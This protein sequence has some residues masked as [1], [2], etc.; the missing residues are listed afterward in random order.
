[1]H[2]DGLV[3]SLADDNSMIG[4]AAANVLKRLQLSA[5]EQDGIREAAAH[6][7]PVVRW[8]AVH[9]MGGLATD[10]FM[11]AL[12]DRLDRNEDE[13]VRYGALRSLIEIASRD[14]ELLP[15]VA[16]A[17]IQRLTTIAGSPRLLGELSRAVFLSKGCAPSGWSQQMSRVFYTLLDRADDTTEAEH[18]SKLASRL[19][20]HHREEPRV[21]A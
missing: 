21:A 3:E 13:N 14:S 5:V 10:D 8:R 19:R 6:P 16:E 12:L 18:W 2:P 11:T 20:V 7:R 1:M 4:W 15:R 9:A 17:L